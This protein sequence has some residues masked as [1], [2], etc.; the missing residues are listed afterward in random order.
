M[1]ILI[2]AR[3]YGLENAG[4]GR[5]ISNLI[6]QLSDIDTTNTYIVILRKEYF[7]QLKF[8]KNWEKDIAKSKHY[9]I[10]ED[11]WK[12]IITSKC[13][14]SPRHRGLFFALIHRKDG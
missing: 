3:F 14:K 2:D 5:Y 7:N 8:P 10:A 11:C 13:L 9:T 12:I 6:K 4:I 1:K